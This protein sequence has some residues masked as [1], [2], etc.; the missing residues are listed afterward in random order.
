MDTQDK[1]KTM[2]ILDEDNVQMWWMQNRTVERIC[3]MQ[4]KCTQKCSK[5][6]NR[7]LAFT[8]TI[9]ELSSI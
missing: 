6:Q 8:N 5:I 9:L 2:S 3:E 4:K 7:G 1:E